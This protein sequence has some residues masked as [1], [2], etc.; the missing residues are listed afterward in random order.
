LIKKENSEDPSKA[1]HASFRVS[2][3]SRRELGAGT[4]MKTCF[5]SGRPV[6][7]GNSPVSRT[8]AGWFFFHPILR[9]SIQVKYFQNLLLQSLLIL[10]DRLKVA[11]R[12]YGQN[13]GLRFH[14]LELSG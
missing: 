7:P 6:S 12:A 13:P 1:Y 8:I 10:D 4:I 2:K 3:I 9:N 5:P 11:L 14:R